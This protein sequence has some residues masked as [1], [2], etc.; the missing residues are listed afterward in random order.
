MKEKD[1]KIYTHLPGRQTDL[2][3]LILASQHIDC[4]VEKN[5]TRFDI[6]VFHRDKDRAINAV[7]AYYKENRAALTLPYPD[8]LPM[9]SFKSYTTF[10]IM[11]ILVLIHYICIR[12]QFH[13]QAIRTFGASALYI[14]QGENFR[15]ITA[16]LLH[17]DT[18][19]LMGNLAGLILFAAP[20]I[21]ISGYGTGSFALLFCGTL[22]NLV[23]AYL[24]RTAHLSIG[25]STAVMAAA[26]LLAAFQVTQKKPFRSNNLV[27]VVAGAV[28]VALFSHGERTDVGAHIFGFISGLVVGVFFFP[29]NRIAEFR[30]KNKLFLLLTVLIL[31]SSI[32]CGV[33]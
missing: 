24:H 14:L 22:G 9:S 15:T 5:G 1:T 29:L 31:L 3:V 16:L 7:T 28:L 13:D 33:L 20:V 11:G 32:I 18:R 21:S 23:N 2:V 19:H 17:A 10:A 6:C 30:H 27:P 26:G 12:F 25:S 4:R 8:H